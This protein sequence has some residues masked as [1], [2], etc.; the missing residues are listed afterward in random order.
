MFTCILCGKLLSRN[1]NAYNTL[2][3]SAFTLLA[4]DPFYL[5][6]VGFQLSY[7]AVLSITIF[8]NPLYRLFFVRNKSLRWVWKLSAVTLSAQVF[9]FPLVVYHFHQFPVLFLLSNFAAVPLSG[10]ILLAELLL[11]CT[12]WWPAAAAFVG[13]M[14]Q[15]MITW[16]N[17]F[18]EQIDRLP[19]SVWDGLHILTWQLMILYGCITAVSIWLFHKKISAFIT[20]LSLLVVFLIL[21]DVN[22][23]YH[24]RQ[25]KLVVY[26]VQRSS[27]IDLIAG[28][29]CYFAGDT[30]VVTNAFLRNFNLK[31][32]RV[33][34]SVYQS[35]R[36]DLLPAI[37]NFIF[38]FGS[39]K[40]LV[41]NHSLSMQDEPEKK[42]PV[43]VVILCKNAK[44][45]ISQL[46]QVFIL[47]QV[48][49]D[50]SNSYRKCSQW[51]KDCEQ[52]HLRFHS[53]TSDGAFVMKL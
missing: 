50:G 19:F 16:M 2:A 35:A 31:P 3:A 17:N 44:L 28:R 13:S 8:F 39:K 26:N 5:W 7:A 22:T 12:S 32:L 21:Y 38:Q 30:S 11:F 53:V 40:I 18:I 41:L 23:I 1:G 4:W 20:A 36:F 51:K 25:Q 47:N 43:D 48:V 46:Q 49:A 24:K 9:T 10:I 6:D 37:N 15:A 45:S 14:I 27:A 33:R 29:K 34:E 42:I 52:L